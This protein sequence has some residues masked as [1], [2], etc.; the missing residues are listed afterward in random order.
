MATCCV[1][2]LG[3]RPPM[4]LGPGPDYKAEVFGVIREFEAG[5]SREALRQELAE[6]AELDDEQG[7]D[8]TFVGLRGEARNAPEDVEH[9]DD[10]TS[11]MP[12][13]TNVDRDVVRVCLAQVAW[14][15]ARD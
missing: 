7:N 2:C 13:V 5:P 1:L 12:Y 6:A 10:L 3:L 4:C 9:L 8:H 11:K 14:P 15:D